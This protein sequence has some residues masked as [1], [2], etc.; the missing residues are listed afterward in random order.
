MEWKTMGV[1]LVDAVVVI[2]ALMF[3]GLS[4]GLV[5]ALRRL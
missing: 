2:V 5:Q 1:L 4:W 3:F